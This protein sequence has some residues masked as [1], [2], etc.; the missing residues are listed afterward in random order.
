MKLLKRLI[1]LGLLTVVLST[2]ITFLLL[3]LFEK[4]HDGRHSFER[5]TGS[6]TELIRYNADPSAVF[7][8]L[9]TSPLARELGR[10][11]RRKLDEG[12]VM[13]FAMKPEVINAFK[14][15]EID[16][17]LSDLIPLNRPVP[18]SRP[19]G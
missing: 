18:D 7:Y 11:D 5:N 13:Q 3:Y 10:L 6:L 4:K 19:K 17:G 16:V 14:N 15:H 8:K 9:D 12:L 1:A 2:L